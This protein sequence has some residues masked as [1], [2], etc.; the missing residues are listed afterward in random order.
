MNSAHLLLCHYCYFPI[1]LSWFIVSSSVR[2]WTSP[3]QAYE[4]RYALMCQV[5]VPHSI[6]Q[7][8]LPY[9]RIRWSGP[10]DVLSQIQ[11]HNVIIDELDQ[12][13][14]TGSLTFISPN[15]SH[16]GVYHCQAVL[17]LPYET[18]EIS[19]RVHTI[20]SLEGM[21]LS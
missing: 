2:M 12:Q 18:L 7:H 5:T 11:E 21:S 14:L 15:V 19:Q 13:S 6:R 20:L 8:L 17:R 4:T 16:N 9:L 10:E 3:K 1:L